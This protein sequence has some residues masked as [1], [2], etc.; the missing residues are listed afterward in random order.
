MAR[1]GGRTPALT[2]DVQERICQ[3][4]ADGNTRRDAAIVAG[5]S[6]RTLYYW[7]ARGKKARRPPYLQFLQRVK[8]AKAEAVTGSVARIRQAAV[9]G[10]LLKSTVTTRRDGTTVAEEVYGKGEWTAAAWWLERRRF[11]DW[12]LKDRGKLTELAAAV[13]QLEAEVH[14]FRAEQA[15][16][17]AAPPAGRAASP[18][19]TNGRFGGS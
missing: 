13:K 12:A 5:V 4:L 17:A 11:N 10:Q 16:A 15:R 1:R 3:A 6:E 19:S 18:G 7:L 2:S 8:K 9:G 14:A